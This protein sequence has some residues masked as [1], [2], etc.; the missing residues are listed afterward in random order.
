MKPG[1]NKI[2]LDKGYKIHIEKRLNESD[3]AKLAKESN[4]T[5]I[6]LS[7]LKLDN[8]E[9]LIPFKKINDVQLYGTTVKDHTALASLKSLRKLFLNRI[10]PHEDLSWIKQLNKI[11]E[12]SLLY[13]PL[14]TKFPDLSALKK[15]TD[16]TLWQCKRLKDIKNL[17]KISSLK[18][19]T[20]VDTPQVPKDFEFIMKMPMVKTISAQFGTTKLND[21]FE[22]LLTKH[23]KKQH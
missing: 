8:L 13:L 12:L 10:S 18:H 14:L 15:L 21:E 17:A 3:L 22:A 1:F 2:K 11:Q 7:G 6:A 23:K 19:L 9:F 16:I 5:N 20:A 4:M